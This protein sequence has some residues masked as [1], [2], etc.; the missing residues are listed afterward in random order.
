M[1]VFTSQKHTIGVEKY[2][3]ILDIQDGIIIFPG[4][5]IA[6]AKECNYV[7]LFTNKHNGYSISNAS[8][9][10]DAFRVQP[11]GLVVVLTRGV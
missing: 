8:V 10:E 4:N 7:F 1:N 3:C 9:S 2:R 11:I 6:T 5:D